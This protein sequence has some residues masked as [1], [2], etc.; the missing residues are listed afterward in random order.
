MSNEQNQRELIE[1]M[2]YLESM[3]SDCP[4]DDNKLRIAAHVLVQNVY[5]SNKILNYEIPEGNNKILADV[6]AQIAIADAN[7]KSKSEFF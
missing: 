1:A 6:R 2:F 5:L 3:F 4:V 7:D